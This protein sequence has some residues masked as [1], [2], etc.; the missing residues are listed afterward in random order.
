MS[1]T[2][3][4]KG[5]GISTRYP[6]RILRLLGQSFNLAESQKFQNILKLAKCIGPLH[7]PPNRRTLGGELLEINFKEYKRH[8]L[9]ILQKEAKIFGLVCYGDG[10]TVKCMQLVNILTAGIHDSAAV[11]EILDCTDHLQF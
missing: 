4:P 1:A 3:L 9:E 7:K 10:A 6:R 11:M 5:V 2:S 8:D